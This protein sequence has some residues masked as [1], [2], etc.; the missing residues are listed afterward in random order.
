MKLAKSGLF[1]FTKKEIDSFKNSLPYSC[2]VFWD[3]DTDNR[4]I[5][6]RLEGDCFFIHIQRKNGLELLLATMQRKKILNLLEKNL[7]ELKD[8]KLKCVFRNSSF[9]F[10]KY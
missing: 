6:A 7:I 9:I 1:P 2:I 3:N 4:L 10:E 8:R 5:T